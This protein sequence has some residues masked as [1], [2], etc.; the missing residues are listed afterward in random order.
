MLLQLL[1]PLQPSPQT[2]IFIDF[3]FWLNWDSMCMNMFVKWGLVASSRVLVAGSLTQ[4]AELLS[5]YSLRS[6][7][8][9]FLHASAE[10]RGG[11]YIYAWSAWGKLFWIYMLHLDTLLWRRLTS[12]RPLLPHPL[13]DSPP[14]PLCSVNPVVCLSPPAEIK[15]QET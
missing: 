14:R 5:E 4:R 15:D 9:L 7:R 13:H 2:V 8:V 6:A 11:V 12:E 10:V 1:P 3:N